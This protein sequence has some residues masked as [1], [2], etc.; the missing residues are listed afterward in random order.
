MATFATT[1]DMASADALKIYLVGPEGVGKT[2]FVLRHLTG[3]FWKGTEQC[4]VNENC[5][6][7]FYTNCGKMVCTVTVARSVDADKVSQYDAF[8]VMFDVTRRSTY[9]D[10]QA[11]TA[12]LRGLT[13]KP[14]V[15]IGNKVDMLRDRKVLAK[16][17]TAHRKVE[18]VYYDYSTRTNYNYELPFLYAA[19][20]RFGHTL[21]FVEGPDSVQLPEFVAEP[22]LA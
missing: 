13:D 10:A 9:R 14:I 2:A 11:T 22:I 16:Q 4:T 20:T 3:E 18:G 8:I 6:L 21:K 15:L 5:D 1:P 12:L 7:E 19:R 17:V